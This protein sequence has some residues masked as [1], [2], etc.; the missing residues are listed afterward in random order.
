MEGS[1]DDMLERDTGREEMPGMH[2]E[3]SDENNN[4]DLKVQDTDDELIV[5]QSENELKMQ[6]ID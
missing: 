2:G 4:N 1:S 5:L 3:G 6:D